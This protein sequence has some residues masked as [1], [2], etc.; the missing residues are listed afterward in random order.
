VCVC[1]C[2]CVYM[3]G[4]VHISEQLN[5]LDKQP[6]ECHAEFIICYTDYMCTKLRLKVITDTAAY[7]AL[8]YNKR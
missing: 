3:R 2:V 4:Y 6:P 8:P 5:R 7:L 1:A